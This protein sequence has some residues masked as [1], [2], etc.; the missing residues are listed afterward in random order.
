MPPGEFSKLVPPDLGYTIDEILAASK[1]RTTIMDELYLNTEI[2]KFEVNGRN[3]EHEI[4]MPRGAEILSARLTGGG[5]YLWAKVAPR[6]SSGIRRIL[7]IGTGI[8]F[9]ETEVAWRFVSTVEDRMY[10]WHVF[11]G[12][13]V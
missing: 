4:N 13:E 6:H 7:V 3:C 1:G 5:L 11:D 9:P 10:V 2:W 8:E 12:G